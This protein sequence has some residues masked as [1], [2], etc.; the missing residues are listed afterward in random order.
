MGGTNSSSSIERPLTVTQTQISVSNF[1]RSMAS[2][3]IKRREAIGTQYMIDPE[4][5]RRLPSL[6][7]RDEEFKKLSSRSSLREYRAFVSLHRLDVSCAVGGS[8]K[9][10]RLDVWRDICAICNPDKIKDEVVN[11]QQILAH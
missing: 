7:Q 6:L 11:V 9:R 5:F 10:T 8:K 3:E 1:A 4:S 2:D